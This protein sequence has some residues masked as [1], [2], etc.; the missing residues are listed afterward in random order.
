MPA[1]TGFYTD[2]IENCPDE[3]KY[4]GK[5]KFPTKILV[6]V[7]I[8][9]RGVSEPLIRPSKAVAINQET[10][11]E[12]CLVQ[13]LLPFI[14]KHH[15]DGNYIFW[16]ELASSH[17]AKQVV[18]WMEE[19]V[20]FVSKDL[21]PPNVPQARP[22]VKNFGMFSSKGV[23]GWMGSKNRAQFEASNQPKDQGVRHNL[24]TITNGWG[25]EEPKKN[26][27]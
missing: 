10:Y 5:E 16:P 27:R 22:I 7:A 24:L 6:W 19:N 18:S 1:N 26:S 20:N 15:D 13:R 17:Y 25:Q 12:E 23:W 2:N 11:L 4:I 21:N 9:E 3:V 14:E 8:S